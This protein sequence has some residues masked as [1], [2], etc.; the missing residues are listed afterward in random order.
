MLD[1][2][3]RAGRCS[4]DPGRLLEAM[5]KDLAASPIRVRSQGWLTVQCDRVI[6]GEMNLMKREFYDS[7]IM[8]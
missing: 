5:Q 7:T 3:G 6:R 2:T 8:K 1:D 4:N